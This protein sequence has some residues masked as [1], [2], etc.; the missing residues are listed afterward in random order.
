MSTALTFVEKD[1]LES[2]VAS[3]DG[4]WHYTTNTTR[5]FWG[6]KSTAVTAASG[7]IG[8]IEWRAKVFVLNGEVRE[9]KDLKCR[10]A[11]DGCQWGWGSGPY[12]L[13]YSNSHKELL[14]TPLSGSAVRFTTYRRRLFRA[15]EPAAVYFP[16]KMDE[17]ERLFLL[18]AMLHTETMRN[19]LFQLLS[20]VFRLLSRSSPY[21]QLY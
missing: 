17:R 2:P 20:P 3:P 11:G 12:V 14:A 19:S 4:D 7:L 9:V 1:L 16:E 6:P 18:M 8:M 13:Q 5:S 10:A 15:S 21:V